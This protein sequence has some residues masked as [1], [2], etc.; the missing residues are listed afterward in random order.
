MTAPEHLIL[1]AVL[2]HLGLHQKH[3]W[4]LT[5]V[6]VVSS[7][8][9]DADALS[10]LGGREAYFAYHR[11]ALH[12]L[13]GVL[14]ASVLVAGL[15]QFVPP[16]ARRVGPWFRSLGR[17]AEPVQT[18]GQPTANPPLSFRLAWAASFLGLV[19]HIA[20]DMLYPWPVPILWPFSQQGFCVGALDWGDPAVLAIVLAAMFGLAIARRHTRGVAAASLCALAL[21][22]GAR[23]LFAPWPLPRTLG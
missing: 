23:V 13:G 7:I 2:A 19:A 1:G 17:L 9:P 11:T 5:A 10:L 18:L 14:A 12:S 4:R 15:C 21:Y 20:T 22:V 8:L 3:G 6:V 16:L